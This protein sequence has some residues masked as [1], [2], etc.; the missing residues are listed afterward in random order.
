MARKAIWATREGTDAVFSTM[1]AAASGLM[2]RVLRVLRGLATESKFGDCSGD[3]RCSLEEQP[4]HSELAIR[5]NARSP[6]PVAFGQAHVS[7]ISP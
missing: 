6:Q 7:Y 2:P 3:R 4:P 5:G 1:S